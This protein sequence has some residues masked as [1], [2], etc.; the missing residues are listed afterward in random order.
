MPVRW[1]VNPSPLDRMVAISQKIFSDALN[2]N[3]YI[4]FKISLEFVPYG[5]IENNPVLI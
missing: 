1:S 3:I 4:L 5:P 2:G